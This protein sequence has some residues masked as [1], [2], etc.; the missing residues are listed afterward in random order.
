MSST[1]QENS[2]SLQEVLDTVGSLPVSADGI[3]IDSALSETSVNP[4]QNRVVAAEFAEF[5][6][7][8]ATAIVC[9]A[10]GENL[11]LSDASTANVRG[12]AVYGK[13]V[14]DSSPNPASPVG[15]V[16]AGG[17]GSLT[18]SVTT[19]DGDTL[20]TITLSTPNGLCGVP[21]SSD[22][23]YTDANGQQWLCDEIDF[24]NGVRI[25]RIGT[26]TLTGTETLNANGSNGQFYISYKGGQVAY[27]AC[28]CSH[29]VGSPKAAYNAQ[30]AN[31][32]SLSTSMI[33]IY[34]PDY[35]GN[36][37]ALK[38]IFADAY[39]A[40]SPV[41]VYYVMAEPIET[42]LTDE[43]IALYQSLRT[44]ESDTIVGSDDGVAGFEITYV[45]DTKAY[46][47]RK[48]EELAAAIIANA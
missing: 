3:V 17:T 4:V 12:L 6:E 31:S 22:G 45:A 32:I 23:N 1:L 13:S 11:V 39:N 33:W 38:Q 14:Q 20:H 36:G 10:S 21:V 35:A 40:G 16:T 2:A 7:A 42:A 24:V 48:F 47:D 29:L 30:V 15:I 8:K 43:E 44:N 26:K 28:L 5:A 37:T 46:I 25:Q 19:S 9:S 27:G 41:T 34:A 18:M